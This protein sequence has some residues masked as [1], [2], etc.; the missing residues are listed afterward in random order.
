MASSVA[1]AL[2]SRLL[3][4]TWSKIASFTSVLKPRSS[5]LIII[6]MNMLVLRPKSSAFDNHHQWVTDTPFC[7]SDLLARSAIVLHGLWGSIP[8]SVAPSLVSVSLPEAPMGYDL[9]L[10]I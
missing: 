8:L 1:G 10:D 2:A 4:V 7:F 3:E 6:I 9:L 5:A